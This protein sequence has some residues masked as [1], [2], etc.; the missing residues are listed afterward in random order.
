MTL[1]S[2]LGPA[3]IV[4]GWPRTLREAW[5]CGTVISL[6]LPLFLSSHSSGM[7]PKIPQH[8]RPVLP[9]PGP[10]AL[11]TVGNPEGIIT[12]AD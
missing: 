8:A 7:E 4:K 2:S 6:P 3:T 1:R 10:L 9:T 12:M 5:Q 11:T